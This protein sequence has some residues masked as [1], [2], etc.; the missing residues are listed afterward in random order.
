[1][2]MKEV[3]SQGLLFLN[4]TSHDDQEVRPTKRRHQEQAMM[5]DTFLPMC[6]ENDEHHLVHNFR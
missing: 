5:R 3:L 2:L 6:N 4:L 1:M